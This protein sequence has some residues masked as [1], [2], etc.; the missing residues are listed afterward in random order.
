M[1][2]QPGRRQQVLDPVLE[3][4]NGDGAVI[5]QN[6]HGSHFHFRQRLFRKGSRDSYNSSDEG[7][8][9]FEQALI[10]GC[11]FQIHTWGHDAPDSLDE[12]V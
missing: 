9:F 8:Q 5:A 12:P 7:L 2:P 3:L 4:H 6:N 10:D 1:A 11:V